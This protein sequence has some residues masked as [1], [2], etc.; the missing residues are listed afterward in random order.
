MVVD[1]EQ[2]KDLDL[3][4][5]RLGGKGM[6]LVKLARGGFKVPA[7]FIVS[8]LELLSV[9]DITQEQVDLLLEKGLGQYDDYKKSFQDFGDMLVFNSK[10]V[11]EIEKEVNHKFGRNYSISIRSSVTLEDGLKVSFAGLFESRLFVSSKQLQSAL[12]TCFLS[13]FHPRVMEYSKQHEVEIST[14]RINLVFQQMIDPECAGVVFTMDVNGN[15]DDMLISVAL[16]TGENVVNNTGEIENYHFNRNLKQG[17]PLEE[18]YNI[19][20]SQKVELLAEKAFEIESQM[21]YPQD[22]EFCFDQGG[23]LW[24]LQSRPISTINLDALKILDN[25]NIVESYPGLT[26]PLSFSFAQYGYDQVFTSAAHLFRVSQEK[27]DTLNP[28][29][30]SMINHFKGSVYYNLHNWY[31]IMQEVISSKESLNAWENLIGIQSKKDVKKFGLKN[32]V[33]MLFTSLFLLVRY[34]SLVKGFFIDF[35]KYYQEMRTYIGR[36]EDQSVAEVYQFY[37]IISS[38]LFKIWA[39]TLLNDFFTFKSFDLLDRFT[40]RYAHEDCTVNDLICGIP[41]VESEELFQALLSLAEEVKSNERYMVLFQKESE[42]VLA[43]L[44]VYLEERINTFITKY[45]DRTL[46]ELKM[47]SPNFRMRPDLFIELLKTQLG[48]V[49][50]AQDIKQ[51]QNELRSFAEKSIQ[52]SIAKSPFKRIYFSYILKLTRSCIRNRENMRMQRARA[53][54]AVKEL[55][56]HMGLKL[57]NAS[58]LVEAYDLNYLRVD[59]LES[60][61][62]GNESS[63][64]RLIAE[65]KKAFLEFEELELPN[66]IIY[67]DLPPIIKPKV[68]HAYSSEG[69]QTGLRI[70]KGVVK[71]DCIILHKAD[72]AADV[73]GKILITKMTDPAW[74]YLMTRAAGI[75]SETGS[76]LSH[77][78]IVGRELGIPVLINVK[79]A[80]QVFKSGDKLLLNADEGWV[81]KEN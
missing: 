17:Y 27:M 79:N 6:N 31:I 36:V 21:G 52:K 61:I 8:Y 1:I 4:I 56:H 20:S 34:K 62:N 76:P 69:R 63:L 51:K 40:K 11:A 30:S 75:I 44:D 81:E 13:L 47:E 18:G 29:L 55:F 14:N 23:Q 19:L 64:K 78:A 9:F 80:T 74:V 2:I 73:D 65:R 22:I 15:Y 71:T 32:K 33:K 53:Y 28:Q 41:N 24:I 68:K 50:S 43:N 38:K 5:N 66:R 10:V 25:S 60:L 57:A 35:K 77:T 12:K 48:L 58:V 37:S 3:A 59:E 7:F 67:D 26:L 49:K 54:G 42:F 70:S 39:P 16:G 46:E 45:G 72:V